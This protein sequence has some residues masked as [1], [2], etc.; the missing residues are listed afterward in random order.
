MGRQHQ[1]QR[2]RRNGGGKGNGNGGNQNQK[3]QQSKQQPPK[4]TPKKL[5]IAYQAGVKAPHTYEAARRAF[6]DWVQ[7]N[8]PAGYDMAASLEKGS[9]IDLDAEKP[10]LE[11]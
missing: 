3:Q 7:A 8:M 6:I 2:G 11:S 10:K 1:H 9:R 5:F 4:N